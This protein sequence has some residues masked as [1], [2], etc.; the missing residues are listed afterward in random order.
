M[1]RAEGYELCPL[2]VVTSHTVGQYKAAT[3]DPRGRRN[4]PGGV[5]INHQEVDDMR[6]HSAWLFEPLLRLSLPASGRRRREAV[7]R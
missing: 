4:R 6:Q 7:A 5:A 2:A 3:Q 1:A